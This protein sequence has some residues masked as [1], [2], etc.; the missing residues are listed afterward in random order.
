KQVD[1]HAGKQIIEESTKELVT[2]DT[3]A[4]VSLFTQELTKVSGNVTRTDKAGLTAQVIQFLRSREVDAIHLEP[5]LLDEPAFSNAG[6]TVSRTPDPAL[7]AGVTKAICGLADTGSI[8]V[9][10][11]EGYPLHASLLPRIHIAVLHVS[12]LLPS[13]PDA[14]VLPAIRQSC[15]AAVITGP[16]RT[17][18]IEMSLTIGMH[19]P[20]ELRIFLVD[21]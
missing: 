18:D 14:L 20:G 4:L 13:L 11:G 16:S 2:P 5:N 7:R 3:S 10:D 12:D 19:G 21:D 9:A 6:I 15:S 8:L 1:R 17:A